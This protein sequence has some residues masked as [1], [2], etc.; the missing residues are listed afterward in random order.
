[1]AVFNNL[2]KV[3]S[4]RIS[5]GGEPQIIEEKYIGFGQFVD[6]FTI[7]AIPPGDSQFIV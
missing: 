6:N 3:S 5:H 4:F 1:V 2:Q 7:A